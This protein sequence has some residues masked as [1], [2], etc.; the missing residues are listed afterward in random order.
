MVSLYDH[1]IDETLGE[2]LGLTNLEQ[3]LGVETHVNRHTY[4]FT[5][6]SDSLA[7]FA[8]NGPAKSTLTC[9]NSG[10]VLTRSVGRSA[11]INVGYDFPP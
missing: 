9:V 3:F 4:G 6:S 8:Y 7:G 11:I 2:K 1:K 10:C 5:T